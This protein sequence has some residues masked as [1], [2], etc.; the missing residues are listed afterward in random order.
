MPLPTKSAVLTAAA[1]LL[2]VPAAF[3]AA[4]QESHSARLLGSYVVPHDLRVD[5]TPVGGL[6]SIDYD[7]RS[8]EFAFVSDDWSDYAP[9][10]YYR[11]AIAVT[12]RG[13]ED[14]TFTGARI[15]RR[16]DGR[17]YP[18]IDTWR[19]EQHQVPEAARNA[20]G[21][22]DPEELRV[23]P[24]SGDVAWTNEGQRNV[25]ENG[26]AQDTVLLD[27][28]LRISDPDGRYRRDLPTAPNERMTMGGTGPRVNET[29]EG[30]TYTAD[31]RLLVSALEGPL[32]QDGPSANAEHGALSRI[33]V[34]D[35]AGQPIA[36]YAY[37]VEPLFAQPQPPNDWN[38]NGISSL[39]AAD[40]PGR[41]LALERGYASGIGTKGR[42]FEFSTTGADDVMH[43]HSLVGGGFRA[44]HKELLVDLDEIG[45]DYTDNVEGISWG[46]RL[47]TGERVLLVVSDNNFSARQQTQ[48]IAIAV[49]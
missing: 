9:A 40:E 48:L 34:H 14:V 27:P 4:A 10:R 29:F 30:L 42:I 41:F 46:P 43:R 22:V 20:L 33:T 2:L 15:F 25:V 32:E 6:S 11:A 8:G 7:R 21:T 28:A 17:T 26:S 36:Q 1:A 5:D 38:A 47:P 23:D 18:T 44:V 45:V 3:P 13:I 39:L 24:V 31:G 16:P 12:E 49:R 37:P 19:T 35:R